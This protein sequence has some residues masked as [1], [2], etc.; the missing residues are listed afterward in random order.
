M[1][2]CRR[3]DRG[4][5]GKEVHLQKELQ[6]SIWYQSIMGEM[7]RGIFYTACSSLQFAGHN[8]IAR[9]PTAAPPPLAYW[10]A[11]DQRSIPFY[12]TG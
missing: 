3:A 8:S 1:V 7:W 11:Q 6:Q 4:C 10:Y 12:G 9:C 5:K 2:S